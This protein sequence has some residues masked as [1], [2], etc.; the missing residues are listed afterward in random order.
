M[1]IVFIDPEVQHN[2][3]SYIGQKLRRCRSFW[4]L[5]SHNL[6]SVRILDMLAL[7]VGLA[8]GHMDRLGCL[9]GLGGFETQVLLY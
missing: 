9:G 5:A 4:T 8:V 6:A 1:Y 3:F 2:L 7:V